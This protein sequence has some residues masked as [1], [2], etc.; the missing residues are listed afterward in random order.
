M[1]FDK[2]RT[3]PFDPSTS[4]G[5]AA[6]GQ[7]NALGTSIRTGPLGTNVPRPTGGDMGHFGTFGTLFVISLL[8]LAICVHPCSSDFGEL[9][10]GLTSM[11]S[12]ESSLR[13]EDS[14]AVVKH[15]LDCQNVSKAPDFVVF[16]SVK[17]R[18]KLPRL[19][20]M[21]FPWTRSAWAS[22]SR[23]GPVLECPGSSNPPGAAII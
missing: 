10:S 8:Y 11:S 22:T 3:G 7:E 23:S 20:E 4:S 1:S 2:L 18:K 9:P 17:N 16:C 15:C 19:S 6:S 21:Q 12:V 13:A 14:R 5:P